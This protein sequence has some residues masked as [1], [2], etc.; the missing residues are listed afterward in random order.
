MRATS[1]ASVFRIAGMS[2]GIALYENETAAI[3]SPWPA[4]SGP[5][6]LTVEVLTGLFRAAD[7]APIRGGGPFRTARAHAPATPPPAPNFN[8]LL[9]GRARKPETE[10]WLLVQ[11]GSA[12]GR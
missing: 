12:E 10:V 8:D 2:D 4:Y 5:R 7:I 9:A 3:D 11:I 1:P 6:P